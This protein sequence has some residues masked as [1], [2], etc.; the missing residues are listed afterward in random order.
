MDNDW[1]LAYSGSNEFKLEILKDMLENEGIQAVIISKKDSS[2]LYGPVELYVH[3]D[4]LIKAKQ[5]IKK[6]ESE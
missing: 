4:N 6:S 1:T 2:F 5:L 3:K